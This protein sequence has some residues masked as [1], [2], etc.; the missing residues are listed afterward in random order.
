MKLGYSGVILETE[1][2]VQKIQK[3][4]LFHYKIVEK[5][6][7]NLISPYVHGLFTVALM[8]QIFEKNK[9]LRAASRSQTQFK[10]EITCGIITVSKSTSLFVL[11][12]CLFT[13]NLS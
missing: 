11:P 4:A 8:K 2:R 13:Y 5:G 12:P 9:P 7:P 1:G 10:P 6:T 3:R